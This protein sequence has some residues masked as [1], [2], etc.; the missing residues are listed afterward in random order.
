LEEQDIVEARWPATMKERKAKVTKADEE[1]DKDEF[2]AKVDDFINRFNQ[3]LKLQ[4]LDSIRYK[5][6]IDRGGGK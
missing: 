6:M 3:Q 2:D 4:R 1:L 5:E